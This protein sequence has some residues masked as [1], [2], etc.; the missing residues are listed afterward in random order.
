MRS[1]YLTKKTPKRAN[2]V[3][4]FHLWRFSAFLQG[5]APKLQYSLAS[6][7]DLLTFTV[8]WLGRELPYL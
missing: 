2:L 1:D 3:S 5:N 8:H 6:N 4:S 7:T